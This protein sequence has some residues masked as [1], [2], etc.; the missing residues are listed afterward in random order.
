[1]D[2]AELDALLG[3]ARLP[4]T[5]VTVCVRGDLQAEWDR[6]NE[7]LIRIRATSG[8]KMAGGA[9]ES[10]L[11]ARIREIE[12][13]MK[14]SVIEVTLRALP[15]PEWRKAKKDYPPRRGVEEDKAAGMNVEGF[16]EGLVHRCIVSPEMPEDKVSQLLGVLSPGQY[17]KLTE[18]AWM[19]NRRDV[20]IPFSPLASQETTNTGETSGQRSDSGSRRNGS[21]GGSRKR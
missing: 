5:T 1:M 4:E 16:L 15:Q 13:E 8:R 10:G 3:K 7:E 17:D 21:R 9:D 11:S 12:A 2:L 6:L 19:V 20:D 14:S 18:S